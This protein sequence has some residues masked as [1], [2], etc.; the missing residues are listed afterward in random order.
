MKIWVAQLERFDTEY[1]AFGTTQKEAA[2]LMLAEY[3][4]LYMSYN[5]GENP[6]LVGYNDE[7]YDEDDKVWYDYYGDEV[8]RKDVTTRTELAKEEMNVYQVE[9]GKVYTI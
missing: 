6:D 1:M 4:R 8:A 3:K 2:D 7:Y 5:G 9:I